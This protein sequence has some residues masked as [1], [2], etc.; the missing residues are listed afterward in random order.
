MREGILDRAAARLVLRVVGLP[1]RRPVGG[2]MLP[3]GDRELERPAP[4]AGLEPG[5]HLAEFRIRPH[6]V[7]H[8]THRL[9]PSDEVCQFGEPGFR[10]RHRLLQEHVQPGRDDRPGLR[11]VPRR[12]R[13][14][15]RRGKPPI[16]RRV[17]R[18]VSQ[19]AI[20]AG[21]PLPH[22]GTGLDKGHCGPPRRQQAPQVPLADRP[23]ADH[24]HVMLRRGHGHFA[25]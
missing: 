1:I 19:H 11:H 6:D 12:R 24:Q 17:E 3:A 5:L 22:L 25:V 4:L 18:F 7:G 9:L 8:A 14:D 10:R 16:E 23:G 21:H 20:V 15:H 2:K 13:A